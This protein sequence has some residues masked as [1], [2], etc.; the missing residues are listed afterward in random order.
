EGRYTKSLSIRTLFNFV[1]ALFTIA[2]R[3]R[4]RQERRE[5][6]HDNLLSSSFWANCCN[7][8]EQDNNLRR[9]PI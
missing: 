6:Y 9:N 3:A 5:N 2:F 7:S 4:Y 8:I 1:K